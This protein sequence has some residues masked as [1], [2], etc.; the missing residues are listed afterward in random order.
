MNALNTLKTVLLLTVLTVLLVLMGRLVGGTSGMIVAFG[1]ALLMNF[2]T[3]WFSDRLALAMAG[4]KEVSYEEAPELHRLV[5]QLALQARLPKPRVYM[6]QTEAANAFAAG[7]NPGHALVAV[8]AGLMRMLDRDELA[9]VLAHELAHIRNRDTLIATIVATVAGAITMVANIAQWGL[10]FGGFGRSDDEEGAGDLAGLAGSILMIF[11]APIAAT[12]IQLAIS[13]SREYQADTTGAQI[14]GDPLP[15][16]TALQRLELASHTAPLQV[17]P[18]AAH[19]FT[20]RPF[21][22]GGIMALFSTHP[23]TEERVARLRQM[24]LHPLSYTG[25]N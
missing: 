24:A 18:A 19:Q 2:G 22:G 14:L 7:R 6:M 23:S 20:V 5:E 9:G 10:L 12:L 25:G 1:L 8:T 21:T 13:R 3:Y 17:N 16:A 11:L 4:A 15:L